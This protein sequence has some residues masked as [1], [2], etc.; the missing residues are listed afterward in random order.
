MRIIIEIKRDEGMREEIEKFLE[1][2]IKIFSPIRWVKPENV[3][4]TLGRNNE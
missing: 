3:H 1:P 4:I 2:F